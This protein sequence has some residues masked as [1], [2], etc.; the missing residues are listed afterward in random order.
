MKRHAGHEALDDLDGRLPRALLLLGAPGVGKRSAATWLSRHAA[1]VLWV[2][3]L[4]SLRN[5]VSL[6]ASAPRGQRVVI[7]DLDT[8]ERGHQ[9]ILLKVLEEPPV[10]TS[11]IVL[12]SREVLPTVS[13]RCQ[14]VRLGLLHPVEVQ[15]ALE[16]AGMASQTAQEAALALK[17]RSGTPQ[18]AVRL[19]EARAG[20]SAVVSLLQGAARKD[21]VLVRTAARQFGKNEAL[22]RM[23]LTWAH[24]ARTGQW[25]VFEPNDDAGLARSLRWDQVDNVLSRGSRAELT[26]RAFGA[27]AMGSGRR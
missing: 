23:L 15:Q 14:V 11:F 13:S 8:M 20:R 6:C 12:S 26:A 9:N 18:Q 1:S 10:R 24:E 27:L 2:E 16:N 17:G 25:R 4:A 7:I 5:V 22:L 3:S 19:L 21:P